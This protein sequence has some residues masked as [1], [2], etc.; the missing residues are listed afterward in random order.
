MNVDE[1]IEK[2]VSEQMGI[3]NLLARLSNNPRKLI[4]GSFV[5]CKCLVL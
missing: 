1:V 5:G 3:Y 2:Y 4:L